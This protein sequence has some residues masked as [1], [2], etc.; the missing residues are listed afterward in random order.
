MQKLRVCFGSND[1]NNIAT[2][3]MGDTA[4]FCIYD[5]N[6]DGEKSFVEQ[7]D[8]I[9]RQMDH[10]KTDKMKAVLELLSDTQVLVA[11]Q[12]SPNFVRIAA[13]TKYQPVIVEVDEI[14]QALKLLSD[15]YSVVLELVLQRQQGQLFETIPELSL[16]SR[17][18]E[19]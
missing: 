3:H 5:I 7:R 12:R 16:G 17:E 9:A 1:G 18:G 15:R 19:N 6:A 4:L 14:Q 8:N 2:T 11:R 13:Q 10:A